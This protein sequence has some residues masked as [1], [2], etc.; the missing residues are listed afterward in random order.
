MTKQEKKVP[1]SS[2]VEISAFLEAFFVRQQKKTQFQAAAK[3][4]GCLRGRRHV[5]VSSRAEQEQSNGI[6]DIPMFK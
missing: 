3:K 5:G 6:S 4:P 2:H 1:T